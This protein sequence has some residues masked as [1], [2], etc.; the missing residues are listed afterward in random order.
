MPESGPFSLLTL[1]F[2]LFVFVAWQI[3]VRCEGQLTLPFF[4]GVLLIVAAARP[5]VG[6]LLL[7]FAAYGKKATIDPAIYIID[8]LILIS[9][10]WLLSVT[11]AKVLN[12]AATSDPS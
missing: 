10:L 3:R 4:A 6:H 8:G 5:L 1:A 11:V 12:L 9:F 2:V 7:L